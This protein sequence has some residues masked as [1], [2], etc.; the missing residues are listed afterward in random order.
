MKRL[1]LIGLIAIPVAC[2]PKAT[3]SGVKTLD[4]FAAGKRVTVNDCAGDPAMANH[5]G[6]QV[7]LSAL[8]KRIQFETKKPTAP[9]MDAIKRGFSAIPPDFQATFLELG[10]SII[11]SPQSNGLC[12]MR[13]R[14][15][16]VEDPEKFSIAEIKAMK[17]G[18]DQVSSCYI[19]MPPSAFKKKYKRDGQMLTIIL[20]DDVTE[21]QHSFV[22]SFGYLVSQ[23]Y[24][25]L[26]F[27]KGSEKVTWLSMEN[28][29]FRKKK[30]NIA[31]AFLKDVA[32][33]SNKDNFKDYFAGGK[34]SAEDKRNL[35]DFI[36]AE[37]FDS[38]FCNAFASGEKTRANG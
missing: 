1:F 26:V 11:V 3:D 21:I 17:E 15:A 34:A 12:T 8:E 14:L 16:T 25:R 32:A 13:E 37:A 4:N 22:R 23:L 31:S 5:K 33:T 36:Y 20:P 6:L 27:V 24:S 30:D 9:M 29:S 38:Y 18:F 19:F 10:G 28:A 7:A 35:A 2:K